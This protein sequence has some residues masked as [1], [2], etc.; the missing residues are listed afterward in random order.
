MKVN[1]MKQ[2]IE[3]FINDL[4][5][6]YFEEDQ[7]SEY[8]YIKETIESQ[9]VEPNLVKNFMMFKNIY[10]ETSSIDD[11]ANYCKMTKKPY[12]HV[13]YDYEYLG[14]EGTKNVPYYIIDTIAIIVWLEDFYYNNFWKIR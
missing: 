1:S 2:L 9:I 8:N 12:S 13:L 6:D 3:L 7:E 5:I 11:I 10:V 14:Y 4:C